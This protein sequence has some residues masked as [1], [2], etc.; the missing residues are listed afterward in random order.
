MVGGIL[1][2]MREMRRV[3]AVAVGVAVAV[4]LVGCGSEAGDGKPEAKVSPS[5]SSSAPAPEPTVEPEPEFPPNAAGDLDRK[6]QEEGWVVD[7]SSDLRASD[8]VLDM[9]QGMTDQKEV[10]NDPGAWLA[11]GLSDQNRKILKAGWKDLCPEWEKVGLAALDGDYVRLYTE[12][13]YVV[14]A[15]PKDPDPSSEEQQEIGPGTYRTSGDLEGC[16]WERTTRGGEI[17]ANNFAT[18]AQEITVTI[19]STDGQFTSQ[20][21]GVWKKVG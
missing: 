13:T 1:R 9:C 7:G 20:N 12:G 6:A 19:R 8:Y 21:C 18:S 11:V 15:K 16:Y 4:V 10:G 2:G 14:R 3:G 5:P 17:I